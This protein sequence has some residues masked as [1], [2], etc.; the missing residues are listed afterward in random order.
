[1]SDRAVLEAL[2]EGGVAGAEASVA[3]GALTDAAAVGDGADAAL[4]EAHA[5]HSAS[6]QPS[7]AI[8]L[9]YPEPTVSPLVAGLVAHVEPPPAGA[10]GAVLVVHG[11]E[12]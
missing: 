12:R 6:A 5:G 8:R 9:K 4:R 10:T 7:P 3:E 11:V 2:G 1:V